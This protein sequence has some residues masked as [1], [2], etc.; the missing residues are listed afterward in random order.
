MN[1]GGKALH[2]A[3]PEERQNIP[4]ITDFI[5]DIGLGAATKEKVQV[6]DFIV[7]DEPL[8]DLGGKIVSKALD[9]RIACWLSIEVIRQLAVQNIK[10]SAKIVVAF[11]T[12]EEV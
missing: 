11:T 6:G 5:V 2:I 4:D 9:N 3:S 7:M 8:L 10:H 1:P 12:Q